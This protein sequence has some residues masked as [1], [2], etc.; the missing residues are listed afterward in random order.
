MATRPQTKIVTTPELNVGNIVHFH[1]ARFEI[2]TA[3]MYAQTEERLKQYGP[4]MAAIGKWLD[5]QIVPSYFGPEKDW[6][7]QGNSLATVAIEI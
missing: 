1:G 2:H 3:T 5:G 7:F 6:K 4:V